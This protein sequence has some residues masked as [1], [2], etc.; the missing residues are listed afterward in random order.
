M[1]GFELGHLPDETQFY[2]FLKK[3]RNST[4]KAVHK[5]ANDLLIQDGLIS[6]N[7]FILDSKPVMATTK[8]NNFKN[9]NRNTRDKTKK[10]KRNPRATL[11]YYSCQVVNGKKENMIFFWGYRIH[12]LITKEGICLVE[13]TLPNNITDAQVAFSLIKELKRRF[14]FKKGLAAKYE[15][16]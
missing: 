4:L 7:K 3:T 15:N 16:A 12:A 11:S 5:K 2:R 13:K 6:L 14:G 8:Q 9:P 1:C 10:P